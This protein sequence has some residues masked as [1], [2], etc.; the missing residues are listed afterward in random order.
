MLVIA[1]R[2]GISAVVRASGVYPR[3]ESKERIL[4]DVDAEEMG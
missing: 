2:G 1:C 4:Y 3:R